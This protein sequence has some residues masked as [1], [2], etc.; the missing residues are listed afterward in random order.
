MHE[1]T[2][3]YLWVLVTKIDS[4]TAVSL[5]ESREAAEETLREVF[6]HYIDGLETLTGDELIDTI[7]RR[8]T[9]EGYTLIHLE[10]V[11]MNGL[12]WRR[13]KQGVR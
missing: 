3:R 10:E 13:L 12:F 5:H 11:G 1:F 7:E 6:D 9:P 2:V 8:Y 4:D